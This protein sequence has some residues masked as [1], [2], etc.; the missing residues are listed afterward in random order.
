[1][2]EE[3]VVLPAG[4]VTFVLGEGGPEFRLDVVEAA[5]EVKRIADR[6]RAEGKESFE[7]LDEFAGFVRRKAGVEPSLGQLDAL[8]REVVGAYEVFQRRRATPSATAPR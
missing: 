1:M 2:G 6:C 8:W 4:V 3:R 7:H 5:R